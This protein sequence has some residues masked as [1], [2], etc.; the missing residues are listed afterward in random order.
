[1]RIAIL[2]LT[3]TG[4]LM[5]CGSK[6]QTS[7]APAPRSGTV[8]TSNKSSKKASEKKPAHV[9]EKKAE[10]DEKK[11]EKKAEKAEEKA[12]KKAEKAEEKAEKKAEKASEKSEKAS[13]NGHA[14]SAA[15]RKLTGVPPGHYPPEGKC[16]L[17]YAGRPPGKQPAPT[18]CRN[19]KGNVPPD[20]FV[21]YNGKDWDARYDW[22]RAKRGSVPQELLEIL[23]SVKR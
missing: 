5:G 9:V 13:D 15:P 2:L 7:T 6:K 16:R 4:L 19:L 12:E 14:H 1:M 20:A 22:S 11:A 17:W 23:I 8:V 3:A 21:L 18:D 10:K